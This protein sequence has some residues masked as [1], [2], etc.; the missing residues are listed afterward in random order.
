MLWI[1]IASLLVA[2]L[3]AIA[4]GRFLMIKVVATMAPGWSQIMS[5]AAI[6]AGL[7]TPTFA[8]GGHG[9][10]ILP[11]LFAIIFSEQRHFIYVL[12][13]PVFVFVVSVLISWLQQKRLDN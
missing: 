3:L 12:P 2:Q 1:L 13:L 8:A 10:A 7:Y 6:R 5:R 9:V 4:L 11:A